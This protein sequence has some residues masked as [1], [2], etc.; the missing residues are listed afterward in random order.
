MNRLITLAGTFA[1][2][3]VL[4]AFGSPSVSDA[5]GP[6]AQVAY[7]YDY[8]L[9]T[10]ACPGELGGCFFD[11]FFSAVNGTHAF[12]PY[13]YTGVAPSVTLTNVDIGISGLNGTG[14]LTGYD[15]VVLY[16]TCHIGTQTTAMGK[17]NAFLDNG[18]KVLIFNADGCS[19][20]RP[21]GPASYLGFRFPFTTSEPVAPGP[22]GVY[23]LVV[24]NSLTTGVLAQASCSTTPCTIPGDA[25]GD[26]S[27]F[28]TQ[29]PAWCLSI[30]GTNMVPTTGPI[31]AYARTAHGLAIYDGEDFFSTNSA[32]AHFQDR[33]RQYAKADVG[34]GPSS[35]LRAARRWHH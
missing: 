27:V 19:A 17:I 14:T 32:A 6:S 8:N 11:I 4:G 26:A 10:G 21:Y 20:A 9:D 7:V 18:G 24:P 30:A 28:V 13:T 3:L 16:D 35:L 31:Q 5:A 12:S 33:V 15:T 1:V 25:V 2:V 22:Q 29:D 34:P 23:T